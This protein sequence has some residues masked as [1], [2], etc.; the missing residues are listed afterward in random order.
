MI[1][2]I[3]SVSYF[4]SFY[5]VYEDKDKNG[6]RWKQALE[7]SVTPTIDSNLKDKINN[8]EKSFRDEYQYQY[9]PEE[10]EYPLQPK[11]ID[12]IIDDG[13]SA[14]FNNDDIVDEEEA[15]DHFAKWKEY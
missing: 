10:A 3:L 2:S 14:S 13:K 4:S 6:Y 5:E 9:N 1:S 15:I 11:Y 12:E 8:N 7:G